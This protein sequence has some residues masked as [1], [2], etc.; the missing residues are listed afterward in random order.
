VSDRTAIE[1]TQATWNPVTGCTKVSEGCRNCYAERLAERLRRMGNPKYR[2]G[3][4]VTLHP[5]SLGLPEK[6]TRPR[7]VFVDSMGDLF[8]EDVPAE[9]I[10]RVV[11]TMAHTPQHTYQVLTK[12]SER[13]AE[14]S[15]RVRWPQN[16]W[17]GVSVESADH[18]ARIEV[19][20]AVNASIRFVSFEPLLGPIPTSD[21]SKVDWAIVGGE[22]GPGARPVSGDWVRGL[23]DQCIEARV[24]FFFKQWGGVRRTVAGRI[25]DGRTWDEV[26]RSEPQV[27]GPDLVASGL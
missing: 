9:F 23:R 6:W 8:H 24:A 22:S 20:K 13:L 17:I 14:I 4:G 19:L 10:L 16:V 26:P 21:L 12:R 27:G 2:N 11:S 7:M 25:L 1:W 5:D 15:Q 3:F 18:L